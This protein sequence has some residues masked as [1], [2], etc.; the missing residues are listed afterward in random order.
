MIFGAIIISISAFPNF[1]EF[2]RLLGVLAKL[3]F[4]IFSVFYFFT[5]LLII[6]RRLDFWGAMEFSRRTVQRRIF[7][8]LIFDF[9]GFLLIVPSGIAFFIGIR[10]H[11]LELPN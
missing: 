7:A 10:P 5:P 4:L 2:S 3:A 9:L 11:S 8:F 1:L 6:D